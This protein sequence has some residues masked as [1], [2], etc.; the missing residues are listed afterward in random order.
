MTNHR[1]VIAQKIKAIRNARGE[2]Q[3]QFAAAFNRTE[4]FGLKTSGANISRYET[5]SMGVSAEKYLKF[6][7]MR[8]SH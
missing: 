7:S 5:Q 3:E 1:K 8:N 2:T 6:L 4:P